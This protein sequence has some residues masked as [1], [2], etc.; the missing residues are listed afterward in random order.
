M[1]RH[2]LLIPGLFF[3]VILVYE[4]Y[5]SIMPGNLLPAAKRIIHNV[6]EKFFSDE[7]IRKAEFL[8]GLNELKVI[9]GLTCGAD[10]YYLPKSS[11]TLTISSSSLGFT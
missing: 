6:K 5:Y 10:R 3:S 8:L 7:E 4:Q 9:S 11:C 2:L 1:H